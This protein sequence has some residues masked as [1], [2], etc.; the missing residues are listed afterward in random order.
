[1]RLLTEYR[2]KVFLSCLSGILLLLSFP[3]F[4]LTF[5]SFFVFIPIFFV[6]QKEKPK[7]AFFFSFVCGLLFY[8]GLLYWIN[9]DPV[10]TWVRP[11]LYLGFI[12]IVGYLSLHFALIFLLSR[13]LAIR[14]NLGF[15]FIVPFILVVDEFI[16]SLGFLA[17]PW[18]SLGYTQTRHLAFIQ[19]AEF[20]GVFGVSFWVALI[21]GVIF[22][23]VNLK[24]HHVLLFLRSFVMLWFLV[25]LF[26]VPYLYGRFCISKKEYEKV[27]VALIQ[28]N[29][30]QSVKWDER[31]QRETIE[32]FLSLS[33]EA[34]NKTPELFVWPET[35]LPT[36]L[37]YDSAAYSTIRTLPCSTGVPLL[38]GAPHWIPGAK[39]GEGRYYNS[40]FLIDESGRIAG[41][42]SK[43][44]LVPFGEKFPLAETFPVLRH[45]N[46]GE[47]DFSS[48]KEMTILSHKKGPFAVLI[49]FESIFPGLVREFV[50]RGA[51]FLV[52]ITNDSWFGKTGAARQ[53]AEM[54]VF[55]A[56]E[57]R[58]SIARCA[59]S[60]ISMFIDPYGRIS[61]ATPIF[62]REIR[63]G[64]IPL[65]VKE[66]FYTKYGALFAWGCMMI[67]V[68]LILGGTIVVSVFE[69][70]VRGNSAS[71]L[72]FR[73]F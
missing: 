8:L 44:H 25:L 30:D 63:V 1:M 68:L 13:W 54:V 57:N 41:E 6:V 67:V 21:N 38:T 24:R 39:L 7:G 69:G 18:G 10:E 72:P 47:G 32:I 28:G 34:M 31:F 29:I 16:R 53:H 55:R 27:M 65:K 48:G 22:E 59:N 61:Q 49:C 71:P 42:Y 33:K 58:I 14:L 73:I 51:R 23:I 60:G 37:Y 19:F 35:A 45:L 2:K 20:T 17:F 66:T 12:L 15:N 46:F 36:Y 40:A 56:I 9:L 52:N 64:E 11:L 62:T 3:P 4:S 50:K 5:F 70:K 26:L 43:I